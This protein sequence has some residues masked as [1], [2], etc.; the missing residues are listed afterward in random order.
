V[1]CKNAADLQIVSP[2]SVQ[3]T[4]PGTLKLNAY[5]IPGTLGTAGQVLTSDGVNTASWGTIGLFS[6]TQPATCGNT[7]V[8][9][10]LMNLTSPGGSNTIPAYYLF[11]TGKT[12]VFNMSGVALTTNLNLSSLRLR[13]K[14]AT[15]TVCDS[16]FVSMANIG[17]G[18]SWSIRIQTMWT[19]TNLKSN[20]SFVYGSQPSTVGSFNSVGTVAFDPTI[21][22]TFS[23]TAQW[24]AASVNATMTSNSCVISPIF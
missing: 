16:G 12:I 5:T 2:A 24:N 15:N 8:E 11:P 4:F 20:L 7:A 19:G 14:T 23:I 10:T 3:M 13:L 22:Q 21:P 6:Q 9:T 18:V 17:G 1:S